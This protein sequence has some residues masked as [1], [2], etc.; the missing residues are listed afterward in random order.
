MNGY[1]YVGK[2]CG[3]PEIV[4][5]MFNAAVLSGMNP[6]TKVT[7][8]GDGGIGLKE[9]SEIQFPNIQFIPDKI[10]LRDHLSDTAEA[11]GIQ[12]KERGVRVKS[13]PERISRGESEQ[14]TSES[15]NGYENKGNNRVKRLIGYLS[16]FSGCTDYDEFKEKGCPTGSGEV[17]S[18]H[19][20]VPQKRLKLP[21]ACRHPN[22]VNP[23][24]ALRVLRANDW[25]NNF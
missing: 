18:A 21:G 23:M 1:L 15:E 6:N 10:H 4:G 11:L 16:R 8:V 24:P 7:G 3:Y 22:S 19:H 9:E 5:Q 2:M 14:V 13:R 25:R 20:S 17:E 12:E